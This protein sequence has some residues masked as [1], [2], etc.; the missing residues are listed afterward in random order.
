MELMSL[1]ATNAL[2]EMELMSLI[3]Q[4]QL[5]MLPYYYPQL[6]SLFQ[7]QQQMP[8]LNFSPN[9]ESSSQS[10]PLDL[11]LYRQQSSKTESKT[12]RECEC[13][14]CGRSFSRPWLLKGKGHHQTLDYNY[15]EEKQ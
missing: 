13:P 14:V 4:E 7:H 10:K 2:A 5:L 11:S 3:Y 15:R 12:R 9:L 6:P 8:T 1:I